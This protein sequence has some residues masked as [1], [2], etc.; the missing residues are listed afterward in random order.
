MVLR[1]PLAAAAR[2]DHASYLDVLLVFVVVWLFCG[3]VPP[4][5]GQFTCST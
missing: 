5:S 2:P 1:V 3:R 4:L